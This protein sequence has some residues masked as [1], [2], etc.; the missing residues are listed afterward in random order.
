[1][2]I[3]GASKAEIL[4]E[5]TTHTTASWRAAVLCRFRTIGNRPKSARGSAHSKTWRRLGSFPAP[6][7]LSASAAP[8][9]PA[10]PG[11]E[12]FGANATGGRGGDVYYVTNLED[13]G[14]GSLR[15]GIASARGPRTI[16]FKVSGNLKLRDSL[17][18]NKP[19][20]TIAGQTAPGDG[21]CFQDYTFGIHASDVIVRHVRSRL[22]TNARVEDDA[23]GINAGTN[24]IV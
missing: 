7:A 16:L 10:F 4:M 22:G 3:C 12:G 8:A 2:K 24:I 17:N 23:I 20:I 13:T 11:A 6:L 5:M 21:I 9:L 1:M 19:N 14:P 15:H 18:V